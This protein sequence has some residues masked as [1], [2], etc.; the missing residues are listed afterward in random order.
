[1]MSSFVNR[2]LTP[3]EEDCPS[4]LWVLPGSETGWR[5]RRQAAQPE[6]Q[7]TIAVC[8]GESKG[9]AE[10]VRVVSWVATRGVY[11]GRMVVQPQ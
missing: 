7:S 2:N 5:R 8:R 10:L 11:Q 6:P 3:A 4:G 9:G 1:M